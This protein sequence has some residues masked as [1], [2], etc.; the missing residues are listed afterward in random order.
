MVVYG[1]DIL[2][3]GNISEIMS[4]CLHLFGNDNSAIAVKWAEGTA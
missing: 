3:K 4:R 2:R 1:Y